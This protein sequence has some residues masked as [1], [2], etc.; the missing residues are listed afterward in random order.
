M[1]IKQTRLLRKFISEFGA[2]LIGIAD[3]SKYNDMENL[4]IN[5]DLFQKLS[6]GISVGIKL[7]DEI[8][9]SIENKPTVEYADLY[10]K[11]NKDLDLIAEN[12]R[13]YIE[14]KGFIAYVVPASK[15]VDDKNLKGEI[16]HKTIARIAGIGWQGKSLLI[17]NPE[18][19][20]R[21]RMVTILTDMQ[22]EPDKPI[23]N[24][25]S[26]CNICKVSCPA[27]AIKGVKLLDR[28]YYENREEAVD[29]KKC[30]E[31]L[32]EFNL[33]D[34][35]NATVCGVCVKVCPWGR[36]GGKK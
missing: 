18:F 32:C 10:R 3:L 12:V 23:K 19:G 36:K 34:C 2:N 26:N 31:K 20:P 25:C 7:D 21:F 6:F 22:L 29:V 9:E 33:M 13:K 16:S 1:A 11:V 28:D 30:F 5:K 24:K 35:I 4:H 15:I 17:I 8:I 27:G 14:G